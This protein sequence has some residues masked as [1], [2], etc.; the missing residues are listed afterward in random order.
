MARV[1]NFCAGPAVLPLEVLEEAQATLIDYRGSGMSLMECSHRGKEYMAVQDEA[2]ANLRELLRLTD[3]YAVLLLQGGASGQFAMVPMNLLPPGS[4]ADYTR[5]GI[6]AIKAIKEAKLIGKV[7]VAADTADALPT[8][9]PRVDELTLTPGA[10]YVHLTSNE[11]ISGAQWKAF[12]RTDAPLVADMSSDMLSR[13]FDATQFG[14]IYAGAQKNLGPSGVTLVVVRKELAKRVPATVPMIFRY[15]THIDE[16]S[17]YNTPPCFS[18]YILML[19]TRWIKKVGLETLYRRNV[20]KAARLYAAIDASGGYYRGSAAKECRSDMNVTFR[21]PTEALEEQFA[22][23]SSAAGLKQ[24]KGHRS[25]GGLRAS[26]Y[27]AF[28]VEGVD[29]LVAFMKDFQRR[30]G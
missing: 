22:K 28:P 11:T 23:E 21:L 6:W 4:V 27:N 1:Y 30:N 8:R 17:M 26:I 18:V 16:G 25:V 12:P 14:L 10:A 5:S 2:V 7:N 20:D 9:V 24:L 13:P 19:V 29:A 15:Q 3:D